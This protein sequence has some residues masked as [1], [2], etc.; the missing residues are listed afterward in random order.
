MH[1]KSLTASNVSLRFKNKFSESRKRNNFLTQG[2]GRRDSAGR[3]TYHEGS[4]A[5]VGSNERQV[6]NTFSS[7]Y[8]INAHRTFGASASILNQQVNMTKMMMMSQKKAKAKNNTKILQ[9]TKA[10]AQMKPYYHSQNSG[11]KVPNFQS[12]RPNT[13]ASPK[14]ALGTMNRTLEMQQRQ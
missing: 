6:Y 9:T 2:G 4:E 5:R 11:S 10:S 3:D 1:L 12:N 14:K 13:S 7:N 8:I